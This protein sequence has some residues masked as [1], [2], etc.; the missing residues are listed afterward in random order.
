MCNQKDYGLSENLPET[1]KEQAA[2]A[3]DTAPEQSVPLTKKYI[4]AIL[5]R[6]KYSHHH[7]YALIET[8]PEDDF[9][10]VRRYSYR[11]YTEETRGYV[12]QPYSL[13]GFYAGAASFHVRDE[14]IIVFGRENLCYESPTIVKNI[15]MLY[16]SYLTDRC[17]EAIWSNETIKV[18]PALAKQYGLTR[19]DALVVR[20]RLDAINTAIVTR[21]QKQYDDLKGLSCIRK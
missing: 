14:F 17:E 21:L 10:I 6:L 8:L 15:E 18:T 5:G 3:F 1:D 2:C 12:F 19:S 20:K 9:A 16:D 4:K 7:I 13:K 11:D